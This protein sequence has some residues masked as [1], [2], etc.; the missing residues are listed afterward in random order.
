[1]AV[2]EDVYILEMGH[3]GGG[4]IDSLPLLVDELDSEDLPFELASELK[5][6]FSSLWL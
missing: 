4:E 5:R 6:S 1:M 3:N 2:S